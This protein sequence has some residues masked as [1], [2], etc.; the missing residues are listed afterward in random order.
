MQQDFLFVPRDRRRRH[1]LALSF[2]AFTSRKVDLR[3]PF[4]IRT[5]SCMIGDASSKAAGRGTFCYNVTE[6][7]VMLLD[8][9]GIVNR[10]EGDALRFYRDLLGLGKIKESS[11]S[12]ELAEKLFSF[13]GEIK[14]LVYGK[15]NLK[16]EI[17]IIPGF[18][19]PSP[20]IPHFCNQLPDLP[21]FLE[22]AKGEGVRVIAAE[23]G[24]RT[25]YFAEDF[26]G[27]RIEL[28]EQAP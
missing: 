14:M 1:C 7:G 5:P 21:A 13:S 4:W 9:V 6:G 18:T 28:K 24:G 26:S 20:A 17:F 22:R 2:S 27:N 19:P 12:P 16:V 25:V 11:V 3:R 15:E 8:H 23:R 10:D